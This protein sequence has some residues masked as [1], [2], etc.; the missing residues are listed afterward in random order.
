MKLELMTALNVVRGT[1]LQD[2]KRVDIEILLQI[3]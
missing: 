3:E 2:V 1:K